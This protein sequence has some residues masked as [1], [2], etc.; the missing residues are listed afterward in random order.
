MRSCLIDATE[1][2]TAKSIRSRMNQNDLFEANN[3]E[4]VGTNMTKR[5]LMYLQHSFIARFMSGG[6]ILI[7]SEQ[8]LIFI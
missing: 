4:H 2:N 1:G 7:I 3:E 8:N 6:N 5:T